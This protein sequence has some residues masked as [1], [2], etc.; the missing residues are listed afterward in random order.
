M[1][2]RRRFWLCRTASS[3]RFRSVMSRML[4]WITWASP[5]SYVLLTNSTWIWR[6]SLVARGRSSYRM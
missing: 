1:R 6:P 4:H 5:A 3:A 2:S